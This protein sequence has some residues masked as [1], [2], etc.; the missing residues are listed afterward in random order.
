[1]DK[2]LTKFNCS[3]P[4]ASTEANRSQLINELN[5][6]SLEDDLGE[7]VT[8][9]EYNPRIRDKVRRHYIRTGPCQSLLKK[10]PTT[11]IGNR[12]RQFVSNWYKGPHSK[13]LEYSMKKDA[14]YCLCFYL[15]KNEF[16]YGNAGEFYTKNGFW[17]WNR[18]LERFH[19][20]VGGV[21]SVHDKCFKKMLDLSNHHQSIQ[22]VLEKHSKKEKSDYHMHLEASIDVA[23]LLLHHRLPFR[24]HDKSES[25]TNQGFFLGFLRWHG[26]KHPDVEK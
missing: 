25:S 5:L 14:A 24:G 2:F 21:N 12:G 22:V 15:F 19:L 6:G 1:M 10:F 18:A 9:A 13:W 8:I 11:Q 16:V 20:H 23:R 3:Q 26:D 4:S 17:G 7:R